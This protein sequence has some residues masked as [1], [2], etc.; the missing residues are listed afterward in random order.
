MLLAAADGFAAAGYAAV[1]MDF[2]MHGISPDATPEF[3]AFGLR[4]RLL[5]RLRTNALLTSTIS[6]TQ[7]EHPGR[8]A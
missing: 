5:P 2:P 8:T 3:A 7:P 4:I 1:A 6:T